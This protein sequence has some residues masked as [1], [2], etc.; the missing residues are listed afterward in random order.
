MVDVKVWRSGENDTNWK[1]ELHLNINCLLNLPIL[2]NCNFFLYLVLILNLSFRSCLPDLR[3]YPS[4]RGSQDRTHASA[5]FYSLLHLAVTSFIYS[6]WF[7]RAIIS[8]LGRVWGLN[9]IHSSL[10]GSNDDSLSCTDDLT[11]LALLTRFAS[12]SPV[13]FETSFWFSNPKNPKG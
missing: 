8:A 4:D 5:I 6:P 3:K 2:L 7:L 11:Q 10:I 1:Q 13:F 9:L 12:L